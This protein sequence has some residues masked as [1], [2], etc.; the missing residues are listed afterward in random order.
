MSTLTGRPE[1]PLDQSNPA[2]AEFADALRKKRREAGG[3]TYRSMAQTAHYSATA[4]SLAASGKKVP[5][6]ELTRAYLHACGV[7]DI[8][9]ARW[10]D[11][12]RSARD[13]E[14]RRRG[15][16]IPVGRA[17]ASY[18]IEML[19]GRVAVLPALAGPTV[20]TDPFGIADLEEF[21]GA[22]NQLR[23]AYGLSLRHL[24]RKSESVAPRISRE[25]HRLARSQAHDMLTGRTRLND[26]HVRVFLAAC[27][28]P[29]DEIQRWMHV[30]TRLRMDEQ[31]ILAARR[32]LATLTS[33][34]DVQPD[35]PPGLTE[36]VRQ[37]RS[38]PT[39]GRRRSGHRG[40]HRPR[41]R[42]TGVIRRLFRST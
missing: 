31:R 14:N 26:R 6:W 3:P 24:E 39:A 40:Q 19:T 28:L 11:L 5:T 13:Q 37:G 29:A 27:G 30:L 34:A 10:R 20:E 1:K 12:W 36:A 18:E 21:R 8:E 25:H 9:L 42:L 33:D 15:Q 38:E 32:A 4:L 35:A 2:A 41:S 23:E 17:G 16:P 22:L 7:E